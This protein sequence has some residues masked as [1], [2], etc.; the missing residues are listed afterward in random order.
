MSPFATISPDK[1]WRRIGRPDA[2]DLLDVR[3]DE[4]FAADP[5]LIPGARRRSVDDL[6]DWAPRHAGRAVVAI[7]WHGGRLSH[8]AAA[9]LRQAGAAAEVLEGGDSGLGGGGAAAGPGSASRRAMLMVRTLWVTRSRPKIDRIACP[10]LIRRFVDPAARFLFVAPS[11]V[12]GG[13]GALR[14][15]AVRHRGRGRVLEP[16]RR[17]LHLRRHGR[18]VRPREPSR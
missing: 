3:T 6:A 2:P 14:R 1:L 7:C 9:W 12:R 10:W 16:P 13:G 17:A 15:D 5:L 18:G 11:E 4:D 8:G